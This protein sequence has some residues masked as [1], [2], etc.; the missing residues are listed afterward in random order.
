MELPSCFLKAK[1]STIV[2][3]LG[4]EDPT[5][6]VKMESSF[7]LKDECKSYLNVGMGEPCAGHVS[8]MPVSLFSL[9]VEDSSFDENFGLEDPMGSKHEIF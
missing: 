4:L 1:E 8:A 2:E 5:G 7:I 9:N 3:N 6:S